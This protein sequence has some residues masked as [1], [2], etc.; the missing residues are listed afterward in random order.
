[1]DFCYIRC[2]LRAEGVVILNIHEEKLPI[3]LL[4]NGIFKYK[5]NFSSAEYTGD[6]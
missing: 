2:R 4:S 5:T 3:N 1:M 6:Y